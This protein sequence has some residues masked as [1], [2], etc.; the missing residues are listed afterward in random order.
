MLTTLTM[1]EDAPSRMI[2]GVGKQTKETWT[3]AL[4]SLYL[5]CGDPYLPPGVTFLS[6]GFRFLIPTRVDVPGPSLSW[7]PDPKPLTAMSEA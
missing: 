1:S 2:G 4:P 6:L 7:L 3:G 5:L